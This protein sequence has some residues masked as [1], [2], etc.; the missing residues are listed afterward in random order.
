MGLGDGGWAKFGKIF[1]ANIVKFKH[2]VNFYG[3][4]RV[5]CGIF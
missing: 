4:Y 5:K 1:R 3:K 2:F